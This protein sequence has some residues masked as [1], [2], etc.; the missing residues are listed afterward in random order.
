VI[1]ARIK[2]CLYPLVLCLVVADNAAPQKQSTTSDTPEAVLKTPTAGAE[3]SPR[4]SRPAPDAW[5]PPDVDTIQHPIVEERAC[6]VDEVVLEAGAR[7]EEFLD[8]LDHVTATESIQHQTV[9]RSGVLRRPEIQSY[10]YLAAVTHTQN[11]T[12]SLDE[13]RRSTGGTGISDNIVVSNIFVP[14]LIFHPLYARNFRFDCEGLGTWRGQP[15]W[16]IHFEER[17]DRSSRMCMVSIHGREYS[18]RIRGRA[19][20]L[21]SSYQVGRLEGDLVEPIPQIHLRLWHQA[22]EYYARTFVAGD[23][24]LWLPSTAELYIDFAGHRFYRRHSYNDFHIFSVQVH[25]EF[26]AIR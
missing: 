24:E 2:R 6:S 8:N 21:A 23:Q 4:L 18:P 16:Q 26:G 14:L 12:V 15:A 10:E 20:I 17:P 13:Y 9:N 5:V 11:G 7:V 3:L 1:Y 25:Q 22:I 19:W